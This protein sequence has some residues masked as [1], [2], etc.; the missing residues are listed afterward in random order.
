MRLG[1]IGLGRWGKNFL[2]TLEGNKEAE[3]ACVYT[4]C[5]TNQCYLSKKTKMV[6]SPEEC[7]ADV[8]GVIIATPPGTH[9]ALVQECIKNKKA[10]LV[11]KPLCLSSVE[12]E[13]LREQT[14]ENE[15]PCL[16][17]HTQLFNPAFEAIASVTNPKNVKYIN[18]N[19]CSYG[20]FRWDVA[21]WW[22]WLPHDISMCLKLLGELPTA[23][24]ARY[25]KNQE[26]RNAGVLRVELCFQNAKAD[27]HVDNTKDFKVRNFIVREEKLSFHMLNEMLFFSTKENTSQ[28]SVATTKPLNKVINAFIKAMKEKNQVGLDIAV[29][30]VNVIEKCEQSIKTGTYENLSI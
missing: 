19:A 18:S 1:I 11:E 30:V 12:A 8:D 27:I 28:V 4:S 24:R 5:S 10:Y 3:V 2:H 17:D 15:I 14:I 13:M 9:V 26:H 20:P 6:H 25:Y 21:L 16:V 29:N 7:I 22:D 23:V